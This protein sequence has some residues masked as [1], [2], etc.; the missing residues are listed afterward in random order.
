M[1]VVRTSSLLY[2]YEN[3]RQY[4]VQDFLLFVRRKTQEAGTVV[5]CDLYYIPSRSS[6]YHEFLVVHVDM[7][8]E[9]LMLIIERVPSNH[10]IRV[11]SSNGGVARDTITVL[12]TRQQYVYWQRAGQAPVCKGTLRWQHPPPHLLDVAFFASAASTTFKHY[13]FYTCQCYWYARVTLAA[14]ASAFPSCSREGTTSFS[15]KRLAMFGCYKPSQV[16]LIVD[17]HSNY[18][19]DLHPP[20]VETERRTSRIVIPDILYGLAAFIVD[21]ITFRFLALLTFPEPDPD[22]GNRHGRSNTGI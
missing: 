3:S 12:R 2:D 10:G 21:F 15:K 17:L 16:Q 19:K 18:C 14:M 5:A 11:V 7:S 6:W 8:G 22:T 20:P 4:S 9:R 13:N 1:D